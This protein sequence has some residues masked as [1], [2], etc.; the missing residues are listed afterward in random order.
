ML[1][2]YY[3]VMGSSKTANALIKRFQFQEK[4]HNVVLLKPS[5][6]TRDDEQINGKKITYI[7]SRIG[8]KA[9][10][11]AIDKTDSILDVF[12]EKQLYP[13]VVV[14][15]EAQFLTSKQVEQ[16]K[17][18][19]TLQNINVFCYGLRTD[20][21]TK[22]FEGSKRLFELADDII[23]LKSVCS[24]GEYAIVN[25]RVNEN[26][27]IITEGKQVEIGGN[28]KYVP[29]CWKCYCQAQKTKI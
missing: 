9:V 23:E 21:K 4:G 28:E 10:A 25:A 29:M 22:L 18:I 27:E 17:D 16:L 1:T 14:V 12:I 13:D 15:D 8:L 20:F 6:D 2:F 5:V 11:I 7:K 3:G 26:G 24:C 19:S